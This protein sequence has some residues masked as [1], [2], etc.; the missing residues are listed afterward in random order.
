MFAPS[1]KET[2]RG[3]TTSRRTTLRR[4]GYNYEY[5]VIPRTLQTRRRARAANTLGHAHRHK[6]DG[7]PCQDVAAT[8]DMRPAQAKSTERSIGGGTCESCKLLK[9]EI[10]IVRPDSVANIELETNIV[11]PDSVANIEHRPDSVADIGGPRVAWP[12][13]RP[14][15]VADIEGPRVAW[16]TSR[17]D[18][19]AD[20]GGPIAWPTSRPDSVAEIDDVHIDSAAA[21]GRC[22]EGGTC[23]VNKLPK[24]KMP[25]KNTCADDLSAGTCAVT[26]DFTAHNDKKCGAARL[27][28]LCRTTCRTRQQ[29]ARRCQ[30]NRRQR[31][32]ASLSARAHALRAHIRTGEGYAFKAYLIAYTAA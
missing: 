26:K 27:T 5:I 20:I 25:S 19:V 29:S 2:D 31:H 14:D 4:G 32:E 9:V 23:N 3:K 16:P 24:A 6:I 1:R 28:R 11:R 15:S 21:A 18:S 13:S 30:R 7:A 10:N 12:T 22:I 17:P 8:K